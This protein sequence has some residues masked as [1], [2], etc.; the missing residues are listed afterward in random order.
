M[1]GHNTNSKK[2]KRQ[3][4]LQQYG[5]DLPEI[6]GVP[7]QV[8]P[9]LVH[10]LK[11]STKFFQHEASTAYNDDWDWEEAR[12]Q[13]ARQLRSS[14]DGALENV[15]NRMGSVAEQN[16]EHR[17]QEQRKIKMNDAI[18]SWLQGVKRF[19]RNDKNHATAQSDNG[20]E[21]NNLPDEDG[22]V[23]PA[24][25]ANTDQKVKTSVPL[26]CFKYILNL[27]SEH[28][29]L[30]VRRAALNMNRH[31]LDKSSDVRQF[32]LSK[33]NHL[34]HW[35]QMLSAG[36]EGFD[37]TKQYLWQKEGHCLLLHLLRQ[38]YDDI[39]PKLRVS[40]QFLRQACSFDL[41]ERSDDDDVE[42]YGSSTNVVALRQL[43]DLAMRH[44]EDEIRR[45]DRLILRAHKCMDI[46]VPRLGPNG[47]IAEVN[48]RNER[49]IINAETD[50]DED[51]DIDW[52]DGWEEEQDASGTFD[53]GDN[54]AETHAQAVERTLRAMETIGGLQSG[55][56]EIDF[57]KASSEPVDA[58]GQFSGISSA[59]MLAARERF[60][61]CAHFL[62]SRHLPRIR[63]WLEGLAKA[64]RLYLPSPQFSLLLM[65]PEKSEQ[66]N[67]LQIRLGEI[68]KQ[69]LSVV[70]SAAKLGLLRE[71]DKK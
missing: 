2:R 5:I 41:L 8:I 59:E 19:V 51:E 36:V 18:Q 61:K 14:N 28:K 69:V 64:D 7:V 54:Q 16:E 11:V 38:H 31:L 67:H 27:G 40:E 34:W 56:L 49:T 22:L 57:N 45:V 1:S 32:F 30:A 58:L 35:V 43:R 24:G 50:D 66:R 33:S 53:T 20:E 62:S 23:I 71:K 26:C 44:G 21:S 9:L 37:E 25:V 52:E 17:Q 65:P 6:P 12:P 39:Y 46:L 15:L 55:A 3:E 63:A 4:K 29:R 48:V 47:N 13:E 68:K 10:A 42:D 70:E 60:K